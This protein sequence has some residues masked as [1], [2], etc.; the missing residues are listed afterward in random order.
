VTSNYQTHHTCNGGCDKC[1]DSPD[2]TWKRI[3]DLFAQGIGSQRTYRWEGDPAI[4]H[5]SSIQDVETALALHRQMTSE[6]EQ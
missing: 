3:A 1:S 2:M 6:H 5:I 4:L